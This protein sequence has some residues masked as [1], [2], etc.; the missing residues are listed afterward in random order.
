M[1]IKEVDQTFKQLIEA[2]KKGQLTG[3]QFIQLKELQTLLKVLEENNKE[4]RKTVDEIMS[5]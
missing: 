3:K 5:R 4:Y 2:Q 1:N